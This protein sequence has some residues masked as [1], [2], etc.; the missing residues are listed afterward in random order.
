MRPL[1]QRVF[2]MLCVNTLDLQQTRFRVR[3]TIRSGLGAKLAH[4]TRGKSE[5]ASQAPFRVDSQR[6]LVWPV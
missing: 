5:L 3:M 1:R 4:Y 2:I 6:N